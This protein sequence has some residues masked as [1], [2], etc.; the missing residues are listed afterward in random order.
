MAEA[1]RINSHAKN[2]AIVRSQYLRRRLLEFFVLA[3]K[4]GEG[5]G[6]TWQQLKD[7]IPTRLDVS[8]S[9]LRQELSDLTGADLVAGLDDEDLHCRVFSLTRRGRS[10]ARAD[11][12][13]P[14]I[15][16]F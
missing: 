12:P 4:A 16:E 9:E 2:P 8:E 1:D 15:D 5:V 14:R 10:F 7:A 3:D 6:Y 11:F 13:W